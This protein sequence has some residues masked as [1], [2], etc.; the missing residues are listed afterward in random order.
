LF[1]IGAF[2]SRSIYREIKSCILVLNKMAGK[3]IKNAILL[4]YIVAIMM[5]LYSCINWA[6]TI[7]HN[8]LKTLGEEAIELLE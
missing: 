4:L 5:L 6:H 3:R 2:Y 8:P 1:F 7:D